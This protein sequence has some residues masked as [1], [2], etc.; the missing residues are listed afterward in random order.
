MNRNNEL[1]IVFM[2]A[3]FYFLG[4]ASAV[5]QY[6]NCPYAAQVDDAWWNPSRCEGGIYDHGMLYF[7]WIDAP[8]NNETTEIVTASVKMTSKSRGTNMRME[9]WNGYS[10]TSVSGGTI[11]FNGNY[12]YDITGI[13]ASYMDGSLRIRFI[14]DGFEELK[15]ENLRLFIEHESRLKTL[16]VEVR[17]CNTRQRMRNVLVKVDDFEDETNRDG[18]VY[19][20]LPKDDLY[21]VEIGGEEFQEVTRN[22]FLRDN[23]EIEVCTY[24][25]EIPKINVNGLEVDDG[26][27]EFN[28]ENNGNFDGDVF[29][30]I[31]IDD[32]SAFEDT[33]YIEEGED[34]TIVYGYDFPAGRNRVRVMAELRGSSDDESVNYCV[35]GETENYMCS[36]N[37]VVKEIVNEGCAS[38]WEV[39]EECD[40]RCSDGT[41][42]YGNGDGSSCKAEIV[43]FNYKDNIFS[44]ET[45]TVE[46]KVK[47]KA[48]GTRKLK[49]R[50]FI[51]G[52]QNQEKEIVM[53]S[54]ETIK[55][56]L[57]F[58]MA[59]GTHTVKIEAFMCGKVRDTVTQEINVK[60][61][62]T[63]IV[64]L[65][66]QDDDNGDDGNH[67]PVNPSLSI[68]I[69]PDS[70]QSGPCEGSAIRVTVNSPVE[71]D[72]QVQV[73]GISEELV[74]YPKTVKVKGLKHFYVY[75]KSPTKEGTY[76]FNIIV[77]NDDLTSKGLVKLVVDEQFANATSSEGSGGSFSGY[78]TG[79]QSTWA[80]VALM[81]VVVL[82]IF[83]MLLMKFYY[84]TK[85][86]EAVEYNYPLINDYEEDVRRVAVS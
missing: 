34:E 31:F 86:E 49:I 85:T 37:K 30:S 61:R 51:D 22:V 60:R 57:L 77:R 84:Y 18:E 53:E 56:Q 32:E 75:V 5:A 73:T 83:I 13:P 33:I 78:I 69:T 67:D 72:Y 64:P 82:M 74:D 24:E 29:F 8:F 65:P 28:I 23:E 79:S 2:I 76:D 9:I 47:N 44:S 25:L 17:D 15:I 26:I 3:F 36:G 59:Y 39:V 81:M 11:D 42:V 41:C 71:K 27:I 63:I 46:L 10:W 58:R 21:V 80:A 38:R 12:V 43:S 45:E 54:G 40:D 66:D 16:S 48:S 52:S 55:E 4:S 62:S 68:D 19:F 20:Q 1:V 50:L 7:E 6:E 14:N 35:A 70:I